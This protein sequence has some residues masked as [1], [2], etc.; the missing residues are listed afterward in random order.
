MKEKCARQ[1]AAS[2][3]K[4]DVVVGLKLYMSLV[5][6]IDL[7]ALVKVTSATTDP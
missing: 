2:K 4:P 6:K 7:T 3:T 1:Q 5:G